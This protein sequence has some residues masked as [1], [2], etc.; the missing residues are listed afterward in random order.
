MSFILYLTKDN[1]SLFDL[2]FYMI[3]AQDP[4]VSGGRNKVF[5]F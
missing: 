4:G 5:I 1:N 3:S 2:T